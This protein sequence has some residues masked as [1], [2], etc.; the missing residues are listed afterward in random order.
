[1]VRLRSLCFKLASLSPSAALRIN[2]SKADKND[3]FTKD[4]A[5]SNSRYLR[6]SFV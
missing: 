5:M 1:M 6:L 2:S 3:N 4:Y